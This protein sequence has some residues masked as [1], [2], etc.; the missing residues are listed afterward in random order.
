MAH[1][2]NG[3]P[4]KKG[5]RVLVECIVDSVYATDEG[6]YCNLNVTTVLPM[7]PYET[8][9]SITL[10]TRQCVLLRGEK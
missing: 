3:T 8:G 2:I 9:T 4:L 6:K 5:D 7:P 10:N 1:D